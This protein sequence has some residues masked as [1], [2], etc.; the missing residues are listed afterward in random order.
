MNI[1]WVNL[2]EQSN[3]ITILQ[4]S[5]NWVN[6]FEHWAQRTTLLIFSGSKFEIKVEVEL[7]SFST[8]FEALQMNLEL[9]LRTFDAFTKYVQ[10]Q[11]VLLQK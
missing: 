3:Q 1:I 5:I 2:P 9:K 11:V 6:L 10:I 8:H 7:I 4:S